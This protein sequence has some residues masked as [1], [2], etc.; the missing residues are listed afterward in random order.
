M[1]TAQ[2]SAFVEAIGNSTTSFDT[3]LMNRFVLF[4]TGDRAPSYNDQRQTIFPSGLRKA[5]EKFKEFPLPLEDRPQKNVLLPAGVFAR[6][7]AFRDYAG[8]RAAGGT[9][10]DTLWGRANQNALILAGLVAIGVD[11]RAPTIDEGTAE[12]AIAF[13]TWT[14]ETWGERLEGS[15]ARNF[16]EGQSKTLEKYIRDA[17]QYVT[18]AKRPNWKALLAQ[19]YMPKAFL[20]TLSRHIRGNE[21]KT[22]LES[23]VEAGIVEAGETDS[24][25]EFYKWK[26]DK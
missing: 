17:K 12:W 24:G 25:M 19:G 1:A 10:V 5:A 3:G 26:G 4:D 6:F 7:K 20:G 9:A 13:I 15:V 8:G 21:L 11:P 23:L 2:P 16:V 18:R 14:V 22:S